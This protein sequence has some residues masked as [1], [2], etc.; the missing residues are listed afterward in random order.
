M[1][2][3]YKGYKSFRK[4]FLECKHNG[5]LIEVDISAYNSFPKTAL[6]CLKHKCV[7]HSGVCKEE[8]MKKVK[9]IT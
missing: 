6:V 3:D 5:N 1:K 2:H 4:Q 7:C 9:K 8:R